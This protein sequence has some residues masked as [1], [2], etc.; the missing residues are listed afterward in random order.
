MASLVRSLAAQHGGA[1]GVIP[2][3]Y[4]HLAQWPALL[5]ALPDWLYGLLQP[6]RLAA[7]AQAVRALADQQA[8]SLLPELAAPPPASI[9][10]IRRALEVFGGRVIPDLL[11]VCL[12]VEQL[13]APREGP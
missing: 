13:A 11:P 5:R 4:L 8:R 7:A 3:I 2:S 9:T 1:E 12:A 10:P 6:E